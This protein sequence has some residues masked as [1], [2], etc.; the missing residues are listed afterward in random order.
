MTSK[1]LH[2]YV[3]SRYVQSQTL[4]ITFDLYADQKCY[5]FLVMCVCQWPRDWPDI[6]NGLI[7]M[8]DNEPCFYESLSIICVEPFLDN[9][10]EDVHLCVMV[11]E[12]GGPGCAHIS[13]TPYEAGPRSLP[14]TE[15][16]VDTFT[17]SKRRRGRRNR[18]YRCEII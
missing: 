14:F 1:K 7:L 2:F 13:L 11:Q 12:G 3:R 9:V 4:E 15:P 6:S 18:R 16:Y 8:Y 17:A 10:D 5:D